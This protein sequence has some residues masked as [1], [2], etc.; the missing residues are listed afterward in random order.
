METRPFGK[1]GESFPIL[2]FGAQRVV[3]D[4][5]C[6]EEQALA[7]LNTALD[8]GIR[9]FDTAWMYS[10]GQSEE[11]VGMVAKHRRS[12]MWIATKTWDVT[13]DGARRQLDESLARLQTDYVD[14]WR[15]HNVWGF[16]RLDQMTGQGGALEAAI[17]AR[18]EG[19]VRFISISGH[20]DPQVQIE[21]LRRYPFDSVL[22]AVSVL[23]HF[24]YS[25]AEEFLPVAARLGVG[26]VGMK[27]FGYKKLADVGGRALR[28]ALALPLTTVIAGCSTLAELEADLAVAESF[29]PMTGPERL[30]FFREVLPLV[31]PENM[32]WKATE[33]GS[34]TEWKP[35]NEPSGLETIT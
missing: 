5:G 16:D 18:D 22:V 33:W 12:E 20:T 8:R 34:P 3:D 23:D 13:R 25:F 2:S 4:E 7:I 11:R 15:L 21:A 1:T 31:V 6:S 35:R 28:Y 30:S 17:Q 14:E 9:Y 19:L 32:P 24:I 27:I 10:Q 29:E 26:V